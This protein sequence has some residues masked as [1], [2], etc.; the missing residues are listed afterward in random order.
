MEKGLE[1]D[2]KLKSYIKSLESE[3]MKDFTEAEKELLRNFLLRMLENLDLIE[4]SR[5]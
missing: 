3:M 2:E 5:V 4:R 1:L